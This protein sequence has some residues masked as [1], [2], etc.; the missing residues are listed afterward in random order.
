MKFS[1]AL[2]LLLL[3]LLPGKFL[4]VTLPYYNMAW[5]SSLIL[6]IEMFFMV[7]CIYH[8]L[9]N[10]CQASISKTFKY[11]LLFYIVYHLFVFYQIIVSPA[12]SHYLM[13]DVPPT[14]SVLYRDFYIQTISVLLVGMYR[15]YINFEL[16]AKITPLVV[17]FLFFAYYSKVGFTS[18]GITDIEDASTAREEGYIISFTLARFFAIAFFCHLAFGQNLFRDKDLSEMAFY[19]IGL[20]LAIGLLL[21]I[22]RGPIMSLIFTTL[23]IYFIRTNNSRLIVSVVVSALVIFFFGNVLLDFAEQNAS[24]LTERFLSIS[25]DGGSGRFGDSN[26]VF[27]ISIR[28]ISESPWFGSYFRILT[29][30]G[31]GTYPHNFILEMLM[32]FG[33]VITCAFVPLFWRGIK[34]TN[35]LIKSGGYQALSAMCFLYVF[36]ALM[37]SSSV[38]LKLEFWLFF[39]IVCSY[40]LNRRIKT[41]E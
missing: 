22:K 16:I 14:K 12:M 24:G 35:Q 20:V 21:T 33:F 4:I 18:Y 34:L 23:Y 36:C 27:S 25:R 5:M 13:A 11:F 19:I 26:S 32:T 30:F 29:G 9:K 10:H 2:T 31:R 40:K 7:V 6:Y 41:E 17:F 38:F 28:Q 3:C 15:K 39:A 8:A 1:T 37:T